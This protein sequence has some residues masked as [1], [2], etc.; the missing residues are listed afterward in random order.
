MASTSTREVLDYIFGGKKITQRNVKHWN[1]LL[2]EMVESSS[3][4]CSKTF[5]MWHLRTWSTVENG[6]LKFE[7]GAGLVVGFEALK[8]FSNFNNSMILWKGKWKKLHHSIL[9]SFHKKMKAALSLLVSPKQ[10]SQLKW[11]QC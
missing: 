9:V 5:G 10:Q 11:I 7:N 2:R 4:K 6:D 1:R 3:W 8:V